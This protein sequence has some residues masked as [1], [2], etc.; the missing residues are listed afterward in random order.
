MRENHIA[1][2]F[3]ETQSNIIRVILII[4][5]LYGAAAFMKQGDFFKV[6]YLRSN[7]DTYGLD[8][9]TRDE[10]A[11]NLSKKYFMS[12]EKSPEGKMFLIKK[13]PAGTNYKEALE[14]FMDI[15]AKCDPLKSTHYSK[16]P[17]VSCGYKS[18]KITSFFRFDWEE[19]RFP[20]SFH[21]L[22]RVDDNQKV[23]SFEVEVYQKGKEEA[24]QKKKEEEKRK[25]EENRNK[26]K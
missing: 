13:F 6:R 22:M 17:F 7:A 10:E 8:L 20:K 1:I 24:E 9:I 5:L 26:K 14:Y 3:T 16:G 4:L 25:A 15:E 18:T 19:L 2:K 21:I 23:R 12:P 11:T